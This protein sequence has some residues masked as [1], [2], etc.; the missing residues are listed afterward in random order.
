MIRKSIRRSIFF[1]RGS[2]HLESETCGSLERAAEWADSF[3]RIAPG[4]SRRGKGRLGLFFE[5][6]ETR[7]VP[8]GLG[9]KPTGLAVLI[10]NNQEDSRPVPDCEFQQDLQTI[11]NPYISG[12]ALQID[13]K[14]IEPDPP[15]YTNPGD[16][17]PN[18][19]R[20]DR[21]NQLF[22]AAADAGHKWVQLDIFAGLLVSG[23]GAEQHRPRAGPKARADGEFCGS[24]RAT[25]EGGQFAVAVAI[26][27]QHDLPRRLWEFYQSDRHHLWWQ[28]GFSSHRRRRTHERFRGVHRTGQA[29]GHCQ[30][31]ESNIIT[32]LLSTSARGRRFLTIIRPTSPT[33]TSLS[34]TGTALTARTANPNPAVTELV[35]M[36]HQT[37]RGRFIFQSSALTGCAEPQGRGD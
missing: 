14:D 12:V 2:D 11:A 4:R 37:F 19:L 31:D 17:V 20:L 36:G 30:V 9:P 21:L 16:L 25:T 7:V 34:P 6:L 13:W 15:T 29:S 3:A 8:S 1:Y 5:S 28:P 24:I 32:L 33:N 10:Q 27:I 35:K 22:K 18:N 23:L 26:Q